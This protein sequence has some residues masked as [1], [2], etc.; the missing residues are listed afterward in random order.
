MAGRR[1]TATVGGGCFWCME[2]VFKRIEGVDSVTSGYAGGDAEHP[3]YE[4]VCSGTTG[5]AEVVQVVF[6]PDVIT[7]DDILRLFFR[8][9]D[10]TT[11]DQQGADIG[12]QYRSIIFVGDELQQ[13]TAESIRAE[14]ESSIGKPV[15]TG[16]ERLGAFFPAED[17][18]Q[19][20]FDKNPTAGYC[21]VVIAPKL[22]KLGMRA[23]PIV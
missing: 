23:A 11:I 10:P 13:R 3:S 19:D 7:Y 20:Y 1:E 18:H 16:I 22:G 15:V 14:V 21:R 2:A 8:A 12:S 5:H 6:N 17:Y 4:D 9:H